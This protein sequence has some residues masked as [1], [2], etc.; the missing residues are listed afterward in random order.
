MCVCDNFNKIRELI[1]TVRNSEKHVLNEETI[2][3]HQQEPSASLLPL[4]VHLS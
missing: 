4:I 2:M 3:S 1:M